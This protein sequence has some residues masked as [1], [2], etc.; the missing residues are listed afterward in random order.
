MSKRMS[1]RAAWLWI[2]AT[3]VVLT[4][5]ALAFGDLS[6]QVGR[7]AAEWQARLNREVTQ[8]LRSLGGEGGT[9]AL[10][11]LIATGFLY[12]IVH[13][14]GPGHGKAVVV[15]YFLDGT[16]K[17]GWIDGIFAGA[18]IAITHTAAALVLAGILAAMGRMRPLSAQSQVRTVEL[19]SYGL[20][21]AIGLWRLHAG[22]TGRL[23]N[24]D[25]DHHDHDHG[26]AGHAHH[27][28][29]GDDCQ[30]HHHDGHAA[31][32]PARWRQFLR[33]DAGLGLLTAAGVAPCA[34]AVVM[35]LIASVFGVLWA[36]LLG[37]LAIA[38]G[39]AGTLA[40]VGIASMAAHRLLIGDRASD[41]IGRLTT[42]AAAL[43]V[44]LTAGFLLL[45]AV[46][47][48]VAAG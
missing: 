21:V 6:A 13:T 40:V 22:L 3:V 1:G 2:G 43:I 30:H 5:L 9:A 15:A 11:A 27:H 16:R 36:G 8:Q 7:I 24:H 42:I 45:G 26:H 14:L 48:M 35:V 31:T 23:H 25:H 19:I 10:W 38:V 46:Y 20:I 32:P 18:W 47:R 17:R 33:L 29:H 44:I 37:V 34:G 12:G 4:L 41:T 39:M 28:H